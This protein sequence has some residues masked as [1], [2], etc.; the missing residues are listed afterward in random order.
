LD[1]CG[2]CGRKR[3]VGFPY[4]IPIWVLIPILP[5]FLLIMLELPI[6]VMRAVVN[7]GAQSLLHGGV[8]THDRAPTE[9]R[10][11]NFENRV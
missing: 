10:V 2:E 4:P 5:F 11:P 3:V 8:R 7:F 6:V 9:M 1:R